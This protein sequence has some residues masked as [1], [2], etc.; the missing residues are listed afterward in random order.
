MLGG[1]AILAGCGGDDGSDPAP[2]A[3]PL[4]PPAPSPS[5]TSGASLDFD[6]VIYGSGVGGLMALVRAAHRRGK[7]VCM[8]EPRPQFGGMHAAGLSFVDSTTAP[9]RDIVGGDTDEVYFARILQAAGRGG[10]KY[11]FAPRIAQTVA[12][13]LISAYSAHSM[14]DA[15]I[16]GAGVVV[17]GTG[18]NGPQIQAIRT[19]AGLVTGRVFIDASYEGDLMAGALG[20]SGYTYGRESAATYGE[21]Y[22]GFLGGFEQ[23]FVGS[24]F[25]NYSGAEPRPAIGYPYN[26]A[27]PRQRLGDADDRVQS[28]NFRLPLTRTASNRLPFPKPVG[29]DP[30]LFIT[31]L[32][33]WSSYG[34]TRFCRD[35]SASSLGFQADLGG[36]KVNWN[37]A[38]LVNGNIGY[39]DGTW[40]TRRRIVDEHVLW[41]QGLFWCLANDPVT[42]E[43]GL[44][45]LQDDLNDVAG[46][47]A[48]AAGLCADEFIGSPYGT[49]WPWW[50]YQREGRRLNAIYMMT[51]SD[52]LAGGRLNKS[53]SVGKWAYFWDIHWIQGYIPL[54]PGSSSAYY[55]DRIILEGIPAIRQGSTGTY[56]IPV[57]CMLPR[58]S[59]CAN[60]IVPV[61]A[62]F[63]HVAWSAQRLEIPQGFCGEAAGELAAWMID[64]PG[65]AVQQFDY[66]ALRTRLTQFGSN[67]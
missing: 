1:T 35:L 3:S 7:R 60:L 13:D 44:G 54:L 59:T 48:N 40:A 31:Q 2:G 63:S 23:H 46:G 47:G 62:G 9:E 50:V 65:R 55:S 66:V 24:T 16:D 53:T 8:I 21:A 17:M 10:N 18:P 29:Y 67:L 43:N 34:K 12:E 25:R 52:L 45:A 14:R 26:R 32:Q 33:L 27:D 38:D 20:P 6:I 49:G 22:A 58:A 41:Q 30:R 56:Q 39:A 28:F 19:S 11:A 61:C 42:R 36:G 51:A 57:E 37:D 4:A 15:P 64:N 5:P